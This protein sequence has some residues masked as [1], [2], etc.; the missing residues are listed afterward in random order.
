MPSTDDLDPI[1]PMS[2]PPD[3][4]SALVGSVELPDGT[5]QAFI[6][7]KAVAKLG[8]EQ[9]VALGDLQDAAVA[10]REAQ[11]A[12]ADQVGAA[13]LHG[14]SWS[15]IGWSLGITSQ[16]AHERFAPLVRDMG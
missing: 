15:V 7:P 1:E 14:L 8:G 6:V 11:A 2:T 10:V 16:S 9:R 13:R 5:R 12:L 4:G 3:G